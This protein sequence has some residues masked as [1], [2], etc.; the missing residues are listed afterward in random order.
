M[1]ENVD[2]L[3]QSAR[4]FPGPGELQPWTIYTHYKELYHNRKLYKEL[5]A[6]SAAR[7]EYTYKKERLLNEALE[8]LQFSKQ[9][10]A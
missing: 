2:F 3:I 6:K 7:I 9:L 10:Q 8:E 4:V 5:E 1:H